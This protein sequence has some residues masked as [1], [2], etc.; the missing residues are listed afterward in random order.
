ME[1]IFIAREASTYTRS[2]LTQAIAIMMEM[3]E[4]KET[5]KI[6][7]NATVMPWGLMRPP[8]S[9]NVSNPNHSLKYVV[10]NR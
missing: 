5:A 7:Q 2:V 1:N 8:R 4:M 10:L 6:A 9:L 3:L